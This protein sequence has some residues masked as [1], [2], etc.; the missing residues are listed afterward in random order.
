M[1]DFLSNLYRGEVHP[2]EG[3]GRYYSKILSLERQ[4]SR[5]LEELES[6]LSEQT[7]EKLEKYIECQKELCIYTGED[8]FARGV[9]FTAR[10]L[11]SAME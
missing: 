8:A 3:C 4:G 1:E 6:E 7:K 11:V 2:N 9:S 10:F 5:L